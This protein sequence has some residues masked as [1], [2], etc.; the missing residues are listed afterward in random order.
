M[1]SDTHIIEAATAW[2]SEDVRRW[3]AGHSGPVNDWLAEE[4]SRIDNLEFATQLD[5]AV[6][7]DVPSVLLWANR[8]VPLSDGHWALA[9]ARF[10]NRDLDRAFV[11]IIAT[12]VPPSPA[13]VQALIDPSSGPLTFFRDFSPRCLRVYVADPHGFAEEVNSSSDSNSVWASVSASVDMYIVAAPVDEQRARPRVQ[14]YGDVELIE[15]SPAVAA[16]RVADIYDAIQASHHELSWWAS[17]SDE[18]SLQDAQDEG[19]LFS[20]RWKGEDVGIVA[21]RAENSYGLT[22]WVVEE[23]CIAPVF[24]GHALSA[25]AMQ[26]LVDKLPDTHEGGR[27]TLWGHINQAN[28]PSLRTAELTGRRV[29]GGHVWVTPRG[30]PGM[31]N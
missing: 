16:T 9:G 26:R 19:L 15:V 14:S 12:S 1:V 31:T 13:G 27:P 20:V 10:R 24:Q 2:L 11:D 18:Q 28:I 25:A 29:V 30:Y 23:K 3:A 4:L 5:N 6:P 17:P 7:L 22:G 21:A 8:V